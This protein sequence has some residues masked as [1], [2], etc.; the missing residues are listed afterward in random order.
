M[1][2]IADACLLIA[3]ACIHDILEHRNQLHIAVFITHYL[4]PVAAY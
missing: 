1:D 4:F 3:M 2:L